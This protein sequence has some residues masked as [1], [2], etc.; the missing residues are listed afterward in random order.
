MIRSIGIDIG[1]Q[2][3]KV[4]EVVLTKRGLV[5]D[6][7]DEHML[8]LDPQAD[9]ELALIEILQKIKQKNPNPLDVIYSTIL[10][11]KKV[12]YRYKSFPFSDKNKISKVLPFELEEDLPYSLDNVLYDFRIIEYK[13]NETTTLSAIS[14]ISAIQKQ[15]DL[16][17]SLGLQIKHLS[18]SA[19]CLHSATHDFQEIPHKTTLDLQTDELSQKSLTCLLDIGFES[20]LINLY[21]NNLWI[22]SRVIHWGAQFIIQQIAKRYE[23]SFA[24]AFLAFK[25]KGFVLLQ[26]DESTYEQIVFSETIASALQELVHEI[27]LVQLDFESLH[28]GKIITVDIAG[29]TSHLIHL[30]P[31]LT[32]QLEL[33]VNLLHYLQKWNASPLSGNEKSNQMILALG[34]AIEALKKPHYSKFEFL[35]GP[36]TP[37][38]LALEALMTQV[39]PSLYWAGACLLA[40]WIWSDLRVDFT[41]T[42]LDS[43][44]ENLKQAGI[45]VADLPKKQ[46]NT[47]AIKKYIKDSKFEIQNKKVLFELAKKPSALEIFKKVNDS[48][49]SRSTFNLEIKELKITGQ[50]VYLKGQSATGLKPEVL[51]KSLS[52]LADKMGVVTVKTENTNPDY[53]EFQFNIKQ[54]F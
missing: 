23:I 46:S 29:G 13:P 18:T 38:N 2:S 1:A 44:S 22:D 11:H 39:K 26:T 25:D 34:S 4:A 54:S 33:N 47:K 31:Y 48:L 45:V 6:S 40:L 19:S 32:Q 37:R 42:L 16:F 35:K 30:A 49:P 8:P 12:S 10:P 43:S 52:L 9:K 36:F 53:F 21:H 7:L 5:I 14:P 28:K 41:N 17:Q 3:V 24:D 27:K 50:Q 20:S 51:K 15:L